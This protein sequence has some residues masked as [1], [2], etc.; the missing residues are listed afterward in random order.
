[1]FYL[2]HGST[3]LPRGLPGAGFHRPPFII[4]ELQPELTGNG[5][6]KT[7]LRTDVELRLRKA[8]IR[9][10]DSSDDPTPFLFVTVSVLQGDDDLKNI[11]ATSVSALSR[12]LSLRQ[13]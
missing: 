8:G 5:L 1:M 7:Q 11:F 3:Q 2:Y 9:L 12:R 4:S 13:E 10:K 6:N